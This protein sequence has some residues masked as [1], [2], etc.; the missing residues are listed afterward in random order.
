MVY[1]LSASPGPILLNTY[2]EALKDRVLPP[3]MREALIILILKPRKDP[4]KCDSYR[5]IS[6][7]NVDVKILAKV[8]ANLLNKVVAKLVG[9]DHGGF[10]PGRSTRINIRRLFHNLTCPYDYSPTRVVVSLDTCK[11][12]DSMEWPYLFRVLLY[13]FGPRLIAWICLLYT[14]PLVYIC[15]NSHVTETFPITRVTR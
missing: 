1:T 11:A 6:L 8:L 14:L 9:S 7:I 5:P 2:N 12:F 3:S 15:N 10:I 13:R 4:L